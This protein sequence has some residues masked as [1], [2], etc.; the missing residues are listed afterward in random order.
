MRDGI[1]DYALG[2]R[3]LRDRS[4]FPLWKY[5]LTRL[6]T[7]LAR[8]L[9]GVPTDDA[10]SGLR[11][12]S[13]HV[14]RRLRV[15]GNYSYTMETL[16]LAG[17]QRWRM[18]SVPIRVHRVTRPSRLMR[19]VSEYIC[20]STL[21]LLR[22]VALY[23]PRRAWSLLAVAGL[24]PM[25]AVGICD[26]VGVVGSGWLRWA[27]GSGLGGFAVG[28]VALWRVRIRAA[29]AFSADGSE[30]LQPQL[31]SKAIVGTDPQRGDDL[32]GSTGNQEKPLSD[33]H[34]V[35]AIGMPLATAVSEHR[36][37]G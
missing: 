24:L 9:S 12:Y 5:V 16:V 7:T 22:G 10:P 11:A 36:A 21:A 4:F 15:H 19:S 30:T 33:P 13:A 25:L 28:A 31:A 37:S 35:A 26:T 6:G 1:A 20:K 23:R 14:A 18:A 8:L 3:P 2:V 34:P 17:S 32:G 29:Y 27:V